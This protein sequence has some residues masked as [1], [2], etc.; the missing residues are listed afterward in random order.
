MK[1]NLFLISTLL[2]I[3]SCSTAIKRFPNAADVI[4]THKTCLTTFENLVGVDEKFKEFKEEGERAF[5]PMHFITWLAKGLRRD[6][7]ISELHKAAMETPFAVEMSL[8]SK[9]LLNFIQSAK[10]DEVKKAAR[11]ITRAKYTF[12]ALKNQWKKFD[13]QRYYDQALRLISI[14]DQCQVGSCWIYGASSTVEYYLNSAIKRKHGD[15]IEDISIAPEPAYMQYVLNQMRKHMKHGNLDNMPVEKDLIQEGNF[16]DNYMTYSKEY[17]IVPT[18]FYNP[19]KP[20]KKSANWRQVKGRLKNLLKEF[21]EEKNK[22]PR[23]ENYYE[24]LE[25]LSILYNQKMKVMA[26]EYTGKL[27]IEFEYM[28]KLYTPQTFHDEFLSPNYT[29]VLSYRVAPYGWGNRKSRYGTDIYNDKLELSQQTFINDTKFINP[30]N[31]NSRRELERFI[32]NEVNQNKPVYISIKIPES[33]YTDANGKNYVLI[34]GATGKLQSEPGSESVKIRGGHALVV[35]GVE[36]DYQ[37]N[38]KTLKIQNSWGLY[39]DEGFF[40]MDNSFIWKFA[41]GFKV[42]R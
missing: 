8:D 34:D 27:D 37:G 33:T 19:I 5:A 26:E 29:E 9:T 28:G 25:K 16:F 12:P 14:K 21:F 2:L 20:F 24:Q 4:P 18:Q 22:L 7:E 23:G 6:I 11:L 42:L 36:L 41:T 39:G 35:T 17:G 13:A 40:H 1:I 38:I 30:A 31:P 32:I 10:K 3:S 15:Q